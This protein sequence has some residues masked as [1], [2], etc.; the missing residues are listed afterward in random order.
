MARKRKFI[1]KTVKNTR[2]ELKHEIEGL[3]GKEEY[4]R[5]KKFAFKGDMMKMAIA[6]IL[7]AA[8]NKVVKGLTDFIIM[9][10]LNFAIS[11]A[12]SD[13]R[14]YKLEPVDGLALEL[15][16]AAGAFVDFLLIAILLYI[17]YAKFLNPLF[18]E[19]EKKALEIKCKETKPCLY[20]QMDIHWQAERCPECTSWQK[21]KATR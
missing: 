4:D 15:G 16:Q 10:L 21:G 13:W 18:A 12:D 20:C 9:P 19:E 3:V 5:F 14:T 1:G 11:H 2:N 17:L 6:F 8:F 7:G